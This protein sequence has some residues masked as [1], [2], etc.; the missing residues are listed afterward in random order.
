M[1]SPFDVLSLDSLIGG[2][3]K[4]DYD[5]VGASSTPTTLDISMNHITINVNR[6]RYIESTE[7]TTKN[8]SINAQKQHSKFEAAG[9]EAE[10]DVLLDSF[11]ETKIIDSSSLGSNFFSN[12]FISK[13]FYFYVTINQKKLGST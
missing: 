3:K 4:E 13:S 10:L 7:P 8:S 5:E 11:K 1:T 2:R 12:Y 9:A 6:V